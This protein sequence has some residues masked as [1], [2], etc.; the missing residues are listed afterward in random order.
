MVLKSLPEEQARHL[1]SL[2]RF[3]RGARTLAALNHPG[4]CALHGIEQHEGRLCLVMEYLEGGLD[5]QP[6]FRPITAA[7]GVFSIPSPLTSTG[8]D[9]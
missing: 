5:I 9:L 2:E 7:A 8:P 4:I 3:R 1:P 6:A